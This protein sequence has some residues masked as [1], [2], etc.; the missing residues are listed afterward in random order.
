MTQVRL[1]RAA[2]HGEWNYT[3]QL[4]NNN[5]FE[6]VIE[7]AAGGKRIGVRISY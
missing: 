3:M 7:L 5:A 4:S 1:Q 2:L 6:Y